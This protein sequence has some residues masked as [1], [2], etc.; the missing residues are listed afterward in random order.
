[1]RTVRVAAMAKQ[2]Q[3]FLPSSVLGIRVPTPI[4]EIPGRWPR[5]YRRLGERR[6]AGIAAQ[7]TIVRIGKPSNARRQISAPRERM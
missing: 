6:D 3:E 2:R 5:D 4:T 7:F 1:M